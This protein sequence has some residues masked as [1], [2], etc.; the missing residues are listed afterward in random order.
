M[1]RRKKQDKNIESEDSDLSD[2]NSQAKTKTTEKVI[3]PPLSNEEKTAATR[4]WLKEKHILEKLSAMHETRHRC[5][6]NIYKAAKRLVFGKNL[7]LFPLSYYLKH[8]NMICLLL[9]SV[10]TI[11]R[12][13]K[14]LKEKMRNLIKYSK[15][16]FLMQNP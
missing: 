15:S 13:Y 4:T 3:Y 10:S 9:Y 5:W 6:N 2:V 1:P 7:A 14:D 12:P 8:H 16:G 11:S